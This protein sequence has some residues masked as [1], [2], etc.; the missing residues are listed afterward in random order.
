MHETEYVDK[1]RFYAILAFLEM[2]SKAQRLKAPKE[3]Q[4]E[5]LSTAVFSGL[6][7]FK[8]NCVASPTV[9]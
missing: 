5:K 1:V 4:E 6:E 2:N 9:V 3:S 7:H 8:T